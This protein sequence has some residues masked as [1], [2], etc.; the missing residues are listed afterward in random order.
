MAKCEWCK[1]AQLV[2]FYSA[3]VIGS[4]GYLRSTQYFDNLVIS[5]ATLME[6]VVASFLAYSMGV[7]VLP[8]ALGWFGNALVML[9]TVAVI[10]PRS[11]KTAD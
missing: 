11:K 2:V 10:D 6:P 8:G 4:M 7:G 9:G 5:V 3:P 1:F